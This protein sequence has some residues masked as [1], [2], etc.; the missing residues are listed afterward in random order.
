[1]PAARGEETCVELRCPDPACNP[2][3]VLAVCLAA[4]LEGIKEKMAAPARID[5]N[6]FHMDGMKKRRFI[7]KNCRWTCGR[8][9][10]NWKRT[11]LSAMC[12]ESMSVRNT[13]R[14]NLKNGTITGFR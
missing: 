9:H 7:S 13:L 10:G 4:G 1:M 8:P 12:S 6:I 5:R 3:L 11:V 14:R 2:Y